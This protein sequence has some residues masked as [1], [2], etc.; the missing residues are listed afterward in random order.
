MG[1]KQREEGSWVFLVNLSL[2][3]GIPH[4]H[5]VRHRYPGT[6]AAA[7]FR[8]S[9]PF[10]SVGFSPS[11]LSPWLIT[12][13]PR[14]APRHNPSLLLLT[15]PSSSPLLFFNENRFLF[16][17][18]A[19]MLFASRATAAG[20]GCDEGSVHSRVQ[21]STVHSGDRDLCHGQDLKTQI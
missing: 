8:T 17:F 4:Q 13:A 11:P 14:S 15:S 1:A 20:S 3:L 6:W 16:F 18:F 19:A 10:L 21:Y 7:S 2:E 9:K 12:A 5:R